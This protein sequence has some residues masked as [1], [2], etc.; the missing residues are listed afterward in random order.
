MTELLITV[1]ALQWLII[2]VMTFIQ[3]IERK[4]LYNRIMSRDINDYRATGEAE[5]K[6]ISRH[7]EVLTRWRKQ[8]IGSGK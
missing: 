3:H 2:A 8:E 5:R 6:H 1:I 4:D 7:R